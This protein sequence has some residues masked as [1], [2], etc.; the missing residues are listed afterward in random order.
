[1]FYDEGSNWEIVIGI[2]LVIGATVFQLWSKYDMRKHPEN[3]KYD[4]K[5][6]LEEE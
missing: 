5:K 1:M 6:T 4:W 2:V 3:Y